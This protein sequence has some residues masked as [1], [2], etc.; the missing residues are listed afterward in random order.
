MS[1]VIAESMRDR[2]A[3]FVIRGAVFV[4]EQ[5]V[6]IEEEWDD[7]DPE[8]DHF[9]A[10]ADGVAVGTGRLV[11]DG[12]EGILGRLAVLQRARGT[13]AGFALV[14]AVEE[15]ARERGLKAIELHA[16]THAIG[17]YT[18][19]GYVAYGDEFDDA[20]I[21]HRHMRKELS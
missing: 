8:A 2:A 4:A 1:I 16:Q 3:V 17:F 7:R 19:L 20:G 6:P 21:P 15:R 10:R 9:L 5:N 12:A 18:R 13:G 11:A 14:R